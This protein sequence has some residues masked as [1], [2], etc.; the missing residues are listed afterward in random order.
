MVCKHCESTNIAEGVVFGYIEALRNIGPKYKQG[1]LFHGIEETFCDVC[2]DCGEIQRLYIKP[3]TKRNWITM[4]EDRQDLINKKFKTAIPAELEEKI[5]LETY[6]LGELLIKKR[7]DMKYVQDID[8][9]TKH[10]WYDYPVKTKGPTYR[11][12]VDN[13]TGQTVMI[14]PTTMNKHKGN[15]VICSEQ[16]SIDEDIYSY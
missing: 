9:Y 1:L 13:T 7:C 2:Q 8:N 16:V 12:Y 3:K 14:R 5:I 15:Y 10:E 11:L 4:S 6:R